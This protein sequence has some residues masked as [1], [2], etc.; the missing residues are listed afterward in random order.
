MLKLIIPFLLALSAFNLQGQPSFFEP[1]YLVMLNGDTTHGYVQ[2]LRDEKLAEQ[3]FFKNQSGQRDSTAYKPFEIR[4]F[5]FKDPKIHF[6][7]AEHHHRTPTKTDK[8]NRFAKLM[9]SGY[10]SLYLLE[11]SE[12]EIMAI[13]LDMTEFNHVFLLNKEGT[14]YTLDQYVDHNKELKK[15]LVVP[16][17]KGVLKVAF[18]DCPK[19]YEEL[20]ELRY[21]ENDLITAVINYNKCR[22]PD[23]PVL[24]NKYKTPTKWNFG[25]EASVLVLLKDLNSNISGG[26]SL[27]LLARR[28]NISQ[29]EKMWATFGLNIFRIYYETGGTTN[30]YKGFRMP[31]MVNFYADLKSAKPYIGTGFTFSNQFFYL[32][33][34]AGVEGEKTSIGLLLETNPLRLGKAKLVSLRGARYF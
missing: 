26:W 9:V 10:A 20:D 16:R 19:I 34:G 27:G 23:R 21:L 1:G 30:I 12:E 22:Y 28:Y 4:G 17:Y 7:S 5:G 8:L 6:E 14:W 2:R 3:V 15:D 29:N 25:A 18:Q 13:N 33:A 32:N 11:L 31:V 24:V